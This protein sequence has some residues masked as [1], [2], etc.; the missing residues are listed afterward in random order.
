[1]AGWYYRKRSFLSGNE[2]VGPVGGEEFQ[3]LIDEGT[4]TP[5]T[6]IAHDKHTKGQWVAMSTI[7]AAVKRYEAGEQRRRD[8]QL[9]RE[10]ATAA[11]REQKQAAKEQAKMDQAAARAS[12][13][14]ARFL[15]DGQD[16][17]V[18]S[19]TYDRI[20]ELM[21]TGETIDYIAVAMHVPGFKSP[22]CIVATSRRLMI[23]RQK[24]LGRLE[25]EDY[26]WLHLRDAKLKEGVL[27]AELSFQSTDGVV[28]K[29]DYLP[30]AQARKVYR[31]C[32]EREEAAFEERRA[33]VLEEKRA[34]AGHVN[35]H[36]S[37][38]PTA[39]AA[40]VAADANDPMQKLA[41]LKQML[42]AGLIERDE[43]DATKRKILES[44]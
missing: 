39:A 18:L 40:P 17:S 26:L 2:N 32:Q 35:V 22:D 23:V 5:A 1:M 27:A 37:L 9:A 28:H 16:E 43:Y 3:L 21:T 24:I 12:A 6:L 30:K 7:P 14:Y 31:C 33:R 41:K 8:E 44:M 20:A 4:V 34:A 42:D 10:Q 25:F 38:P 11:E 19:K 15:S 36:A 29:V 13:P